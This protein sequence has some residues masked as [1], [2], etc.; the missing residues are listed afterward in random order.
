MDAIAIVKT[1]EQY[2][3]KVT[4][5]HCVDVFRG[6]KAKKIAELHHDQLD[7]YGSGSNLDRG[8]AERLFYRLLSEDALKEKNVPNRSGFAVSYVQVR[9]LS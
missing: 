8:D 4:L 9:V 2:Q 3:Q 5:L 1:I 7:Q 6:A